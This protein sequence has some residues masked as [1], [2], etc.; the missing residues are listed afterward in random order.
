MVLQQPEM[1]V[2]GDEVGVAFSEQL[3]EEDI[4]STG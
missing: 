1:G 2:A 3:K 4:I